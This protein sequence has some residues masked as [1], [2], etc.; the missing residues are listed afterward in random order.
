M[1]CKKKKDMKKKHQLA[2]NNDTNRVFTSWLII[3]LDDVKH[4][5]NPRI[6]LF[7]LSIW[8]NPPTCYIKHT[9]DNC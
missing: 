9:I 5:W 1:F 6:W 3:Q 2:I 7:Y 4:I 8:V